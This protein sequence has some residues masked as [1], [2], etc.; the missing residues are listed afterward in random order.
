MKANE[1]KDINTDPKLNASLEAKLSP[2]MQKM[3]DSER[4]K[5]AKRRAK[6]IQRK[7]SNDNKLDTDALQKGVSKFGRNIFYSV[8]DVFKFS[9][10]NIERSIRLELIIA[11]AICMAI[12]LG[13]FYGASKGLARLDMDIYMDYSQSVKII[14]DKAET[15]V[16][17][18]ESTYETL[19]L[20][21]IKENI[22]NEIKY[23]DTIPEYYLTDLQGSILVT[24]DE[25]FTDK[26]N[27]HSVM[28]DASKVKQNDNS[29][30]RCTRIFPMSVEGQ[31][32]YFVYRDIATP[33]ERFR[34]T[35]NR[36]GAIGF[37]LA[38]VVF[39][40]SFF[41][42]TKKKVGYVSYL[43]DSLR[44]IAQGNLNYKVDERGEDELYHLAKNI[45]NMSHS[46][47]EQIEAE[48]RAEKSK[49]ELITNVSHDLRSP[50]TS[51]LGYLRLVKDHKYEDT[52]QLE[53][54]VQVVYTK[55]EQLKD[56]IDDLFEYTKLSYQGVQMTIQ[57]I[58]LNELVEQSLEE[59]IPLFEE[60][61]L[62]LQRTF[63]DEEFLLNVDPNKTHRVIENLIS[64][65]VRYSK[66][67]SAVKVIL[68]RENDNVQLIVENQGEKMSRFELE[69]IF[70]RFYRKDAARNPENGGS[71]LGLAIAKSI[72]EMQ[73]GRIWAECDDCKE[74]AREPLIR[75]IVSFPI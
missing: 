54:Y 3:I 50:L 39:I 44:N 62:Q 70:E 63:A 33:I 23:K 58:S 6:S 35:G 45:N 66:K 49:Q 5:I 71:G 67:P 12:S 11:F 46:L 69:K 21:L 18:L 4:K 48:R 20:E 40:I 32:L 56:L 25:I 60:N 57:R 9:K 37:G 24:N 36:S 68:K 72:V 31:S 27:I 59:F 1:T 64:N 38:A 22:E 30:G 29:P 43:S 8:L 74:G 7:A 14:E 65:A 41:W 13:V 34:R 75:F 10:D 15:I 28:K 16:G 53:E 73:G 61:N 19:N 52:E 47:Q 55:A 51:I 2:N 42:I 26:L 17:S